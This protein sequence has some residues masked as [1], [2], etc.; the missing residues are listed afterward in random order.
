MKSSRIHILG[1]A[2]FES[3]AAAMQEEAARF[4]DLRLDVY[5]GDLRE[6][7][8]I[9]RQKESLY[10]DAVISRGGTAEMI[11][12]RSSLPVISIPISVYD[13]LRTIKMA[14]SSSERFA[15]V[16]FPAI[17]RTAHILRD[18]LQYDFEIETI[19]D[20]S[21]VPDIMAKL[22]TRGYSL[23][24]CDRISFTHAK[25]AGFAAILITSGP[26]S[27]RE[28]LEQTI[29]LCRGFRELRL[30][31]RFLK[32]FSLQS[33]VPLLVLGSE[34]DLVYSTLSGSAEDMAELLRP[35]LAEIPA[36]RE[37]TFTCSRGSEL[38]EVHAGKI[39]DTDRSYT[40]FWYKPYKIPLA[41]KMLGIRMQQAPECTHQLMNSFFG[42]T[43]SM[44][45]PGS[46]IH[47]IAPGSA[48]VMIFGEPG[49][50]K[51]QTALALYLQ[52]S[53]TDSFFL[54]VDCAR[55]NDK[56]WNF[57]FEN[58]SSPLMGDR[59]TVYFEH[60]ESLP[61]RRMPQLLAALR[62]SNLAKRLRLIFSCDYTEAAPMHP[63]A[64]A[65]RSQGSCQTLQ[66][67]P[68]RDRAEQIPTLANLYLLSLNMELN[69]QIVGLDAEAA[70][71]LQAY[72]WPGNDTQLQQ[73]LYELASQTVTPYARG[74]DAAVLL[75]NERALRGSSQTAA[76]V[77]TLPD[78]RTLDEITSDII[79]QTV[80]ACGG[81]QS[82]AAKQLNISRSTLWRYLKKNQD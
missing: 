25:A 23:L 52:S 27:I 61:P 40:L 55:V 3:I 33:G 39:Y 29:S 41:A 67:P 47:K 73:F 20:A 30:E 26:E 32:T 69:K 81:N 35:H 11:R 7:A 70:R 6:G 80:K 49:C 13:I 1:I 19:H 48:P 16:G 51:P 10:Y 43:G 34:G 4:P 82:A 44:N 9:V 46:L 66:L 64:A 65:V 5:V 21:E 71:Q 78:P 18:L 8:E 17:T 56:N 38:L 74:A 45:R 15:I 37:V 50:C 22:K 76:P 36:H 59:G 75:A 57:L 28:A 62:E 42:I 12:K 63:N 68:L 72:D 79:T 2:P 58:D 53:R 60:L 24:I 54:T 31:N 77:Q 14:E